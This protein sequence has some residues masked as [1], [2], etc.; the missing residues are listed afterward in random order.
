[1]LRKVVRALR[2]LLGRQALLVGGEP[3]RSLSATQQLFCEWNAERL[4][5]SLEDAIDRFQRSWS[6]VSG[7]HAGSDFRSFNDVSYEVFR[8]YFDDRA[9]EVV[10][11][12]R[13]HSY[14]HFLRMLSY[15]DESTGLDLRCIDRLSEREKEVTILDFGCGLAQASRALATHLRGKG[16]NVSL[17]LADI[18]TIR[19]EFLLWLGEKTKIDTIFLDCN[20][21]NPIPLQEVSC[22]V[23]FVTEFFEHVY[24]PLDYLEA[25]HGSLL[26]GGIL[27]TN[28]ADHLE[29]YMHVSPDLSAL[30]SRIGALGYKELKLEKVYQK[31]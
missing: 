26:P 21:A 24:E 27:K 22:D 31:P 6:A 7:G 14:M 20:E 30:R 25:I 15:E 16:V 18:P 3:L 29:E 5:V 8:V 12:Y 13:F 9:N 11:A 17:V 1:M 4:G 28:L 23:C 10:D 2:V 19:K